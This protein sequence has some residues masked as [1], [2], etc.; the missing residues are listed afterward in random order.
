VTVLCFIYF[1]TIN[2]KK[3]VYYEKCTVKYVGPTVGVCWLI[4]LPFNAGVYK[5]TTLI[6]RH[7]GSGQLGTDLTRPRL[8]DYNDVTQCRLI[9]KLFNGALLTAEI[10]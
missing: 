7:R 2:K 5:K 8:H 4:H 9:L 6:D 3:F 10:M 1:V